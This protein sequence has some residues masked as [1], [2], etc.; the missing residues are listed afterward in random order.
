MTITLE[1]T[2]EAERR[3]RA[4]AAR[5]GIDA[6]D[7]ARTL[8]EDRLMPRPEGEA[9]ARPFYETATT[10]EWIREFDAMVASFDDVDAPEIPPEALR[11]E[12]IYEDRGL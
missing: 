11:R 3:L 8:L 7:Y 9:G 12:N 1:L 6:S 2:P 5:R 4:E 10:E